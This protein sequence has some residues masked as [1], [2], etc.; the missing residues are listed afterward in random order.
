M[1]KAKGPQEG[2]DRPQGE[3]KGASAAPASAAG[4]AAGPAAPPRHPFDPWRENIEAIVV[5]V[6]LALIIRHFSVEAFEIPTG[7]MA[8]TLFGIHSWVKCPNCDTDFNFGLQSDSDSNTLKKDN[9]FQ[10]P[11]LV[12]WGKC[13]T[14]KLPHNRAFHT[15]PDGMPDLARR[16]KVGDTF[17]CPN[18]GTRWVGE[19]GDFSTHRVVKPEYTY[20]LLCPICWFVF[21]EVVTERNKTNGHKI[22]VNKFDY[23]VREPR[24]WDVIVFEFNRE[25]NYIKRLIGLPG[26]KVFIQGGDVYINGRIARKSGRPEVRE[27]LWTKVHDLDVPERDYRRPHLGLWSTPWKEAIPAS[28]GLPPGSW[29]KPDGKS[30][31]LRWTVNTSREGAGKVAVLRYQR[32][33]RNYI[34]Y[35]ALH[36]GISVPWDRLEE[37][38]DKKVAFTVKLAAGARGWIGVE[39]RDAAFTFQLRIPVGDPDPACPATLRRLPSDPNPDR[40]SVDRAPV[41]EDQ[42]GFSRAAAVAVKP[43]SVTR[44]EFENADDRVAVSIDGVEVADLTIEYKSDSVLPRDATENTLLLLAGDGVDG[45]LESIQVFRDVFYTSS[46]GLGQFAVNKDR[47]ISLA[48]EKGRREYFACGDNSPASSDGR[49]WGSVPERNMMGRALLVFWPLWPTNWQAKFIR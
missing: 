16:V 24:R 40:P 47:E 37:V 49:Y 46:G 2:T 10:D 33:L 44:V 27:A 30:L 8:P 12:Y 1:K 17:Q 11:L 5:A 48:A 23:R 39:A 3:A 28:G 38:G 29:T 42:G 35:D 15:N 34:H 25:T 21:T 32:P 13:G 36:Y 41:P 9:Y 45:H 4:A 14:C 20:R 19:A 18:D 31:P 26:E 6:V 43:G 22:L 7:S